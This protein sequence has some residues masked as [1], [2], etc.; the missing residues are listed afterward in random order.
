MITVE[1]RRLPEPVLRPF[2]VFFNPSIYQPVFA[3]GCLDAISKVI[4]ELRDTCELE[5]IYGTPASWSVKEV[6][7]PEAA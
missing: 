1:P 2:L 3:Y 6:F 4:I 7:L 5:E